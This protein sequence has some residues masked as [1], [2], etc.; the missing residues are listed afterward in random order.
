ML[1]SSLA[2]L[3]EPAPASVTVTAYF[4]GGVGLNVAVTDWLAFM[5]TLHVP[6]PEQAPLHPL[7][8]WPVLGV[9]AKL[10][11]APNAAVIEHVAPQEMP[12]GELDTD[13]VPVPAS[14]TERVYCGTKFAE[15]EVFDPTVYVHV[16][17]PAHADPPHPAK[18]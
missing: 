1:A 14:A 2:T 18:T 10:I 8:T 11:D 16:P 9:A 7:K 13:P 17:V 12:A 6:V 4:G 15:T 5:L 3:P